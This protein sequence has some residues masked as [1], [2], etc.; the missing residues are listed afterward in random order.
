MMHIHV[1]VADDPNPYVVPKEVLC[2]H[3][4][5]FRSALSSNFIEGQTGVLRFPEDSKEAW[6]LLLYYVFQDRIPP[7][8]DDAIKM[9]HDT[10]V[11]TLVYVYEL[12]DK[13]GVGR[14][15]NKIM[16]W[17]LQDFGG[18]RLRYAADFWISMFRITGKNHPLRKFILQE[19]VSSVELHEY[20]K[21][22][23][24]EELFQIDGVYLNILDELRVLRNTEEDST[25]NYP[26]HNYGQ[27][28]DKVLEE[29]Y[30]EE[31]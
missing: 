26:S 19:M 15:Q 2:R 3:I 16:D 11:L 29:F 8:D 30:V 6:S 24:Y 23:A 27:A 4:Q 31:E 14:F 1:G 22:S 25:A 13:Y 9:K 7:W 18:L 20:S 5:C 12:G 28:T 21:W 17:M 10:Y